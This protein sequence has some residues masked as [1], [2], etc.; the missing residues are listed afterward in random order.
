MEFFPSLI[1]PMD[2]SRIDVQN[3]VHGRT[4]ETAVSEHPVCNRG[5]RSLVGGFALP[6]R[7]WIGDSVEFAQGRFSVL[8]PGFT[9]APGSDSHPI[10]TKN[11]R[12]L[13]PFLL[14]RRKSGL[15]PKARLP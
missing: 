3:E 13:F 7:V 2:R 9:E 4:T 12:M 10:D 1:A 5:T 15:V 11:R 8:G 14:E 6:L